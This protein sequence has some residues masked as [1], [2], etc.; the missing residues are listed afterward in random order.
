[1][2]RKDRRSHGMSHRLWWLAAALSIVVS[3]GIVLDAPDSPTAAAHEAAAT[4]APSHATHE[5]AR[6]LRGG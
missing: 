6:V 3:L 1:M 2:R 5:A 4:A